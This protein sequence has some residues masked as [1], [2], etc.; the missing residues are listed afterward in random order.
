MCLSFFFSFWLSQTFNDRS[1]D[2]NKLSLFE[3]KKKSIY[4]FKKL[5]SWDIN[6]ESK[7][8]KYSMMFINIFNSR[9]SDKSAQR[10]NFKAKG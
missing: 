4:V 10:K 5:I 9:K 8:S 1:I 2:L 7:T 6:R 3:L